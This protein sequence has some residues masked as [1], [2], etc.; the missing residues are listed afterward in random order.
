MLLNATTYN[1]L[2]QWRSHGGVAWA[3]QPE[4]K[5]NERKKQ[6]RKQKEQIKKRMK[7]KE[8]YKERMGVRIGRDLHAVTKSVF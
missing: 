5:K 3:P 8:R 7:E 2:Q 6:E 1:T 4:K